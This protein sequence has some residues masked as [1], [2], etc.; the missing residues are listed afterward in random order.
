MNE[1][2]EFLRDRLQ[3]G[4]PPYTLPHAP[5]VRRPGSPYR[6]PPAFA[7]GP[8]KPAPPRPPA[9]PP[10]APAGASRLPAALR[11]TAPPAPPPG[12]PLPLPRRDPP[13]PQQQ[14]A[15][16]RRA[17]R[18]RSRR[19]FRGPWPPSCRAHHAAARTP[20]P[21]LATHPPADHLWPCQ[22]GSVGRATPRGAIRSSHP[23]RASRQLQGR[24]A[25]QGRRRK[26]VGGRQ[27]RIALRR[28]P[29]ARPRRGDRCRHRLRPT[30]QPNRSALERLVLGT[31]LGQEPAIL[32]RRD[33]ACRPQFRRPVRTRRRTG[34]RS[35]A[36]CSI[37]RS[38][39]KPRYGWIAISLSRSSTAAR[40]WT[41]RSPRRYCVIWMR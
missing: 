29:S 41:R 20:G 1:R 17:T 6:A 40:R 8:S 18:Q 30:E 39:G 36:G 9:L 7:S 35:H 24:R 38:T 15:S 5:P 11:R 27:C 34:V 26:N 13:C 37:L 33:C 19:L 23:D 32:Q 3:P 25:G 4:Q 31:D 16:S 28:T 10:P 21:R 14:A 22:A 12:Q 2:D